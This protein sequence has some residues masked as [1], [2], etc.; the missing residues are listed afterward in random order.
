MIMKLNLK[1]A[2]FALLAVMPLTLRAETGGGNFA[3]SSGTAPG[4]TQ[5]DVT[6]SVRGTV[7]DASGVPLPGVVVLVKDRPSSGVMTDADG[8]FFITVPKGA[9]LVFTCMGYKTIELLAS[10]TAMAVSL[11][12]ERLELRRPWSWAT[13]CSGERASSGQSPM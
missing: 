5:A 11:E 2:A 12:E 10:E 1:L 7:R 6:V 13:A 3:A 9:T 8:A 4:K